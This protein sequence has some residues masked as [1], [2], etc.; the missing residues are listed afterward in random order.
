MKPKFLPVLEQCIDR[1]ITLGY[2]RAHK[3]NDNPSQEVIEHEIS[4]AITD[5]IFEWFDFDS[6]FEK[7]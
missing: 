5:E 1:G 4:R 3:H 6:E 2:N 7:D